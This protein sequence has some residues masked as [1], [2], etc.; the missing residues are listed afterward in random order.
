MTENGKGLL[1]VGKLVLAFARVN[2][3][4][5]YEDGVTPE[6]DT[7]HTVMVSVS[8]CALAKKLYPDNLDIGLVAQFATVH[9][10]VEVYAM[11]TA[12]FGITEEGKKAKDAREREAFLRIQQEFKDVFPWLPEMIE[13]YESLDT[14]EARFVKTVDK[15]MP[16]ITHILN[17]GAYFKSK[18]MD[19]DT[20]WSQYQSMVKDAELK[21]AKEFPEIMELMDELIREAKRVA[22][23]E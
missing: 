20:M 8:A 22:Y 13:R 19:A 7:D 15:L 10:M 5:R 3:V 21:Y 9:D 1:D 14:K 2:R 23:G 12:S 16:K 11:D 6:S 4:T 18:G 17:Q